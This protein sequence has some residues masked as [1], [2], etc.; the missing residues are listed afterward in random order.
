MRASVGAFELLITLSAGVISPHSLS[1]G[2][3][4]TSACAEMQQ[5]DFVSRTC[6]KNAE[7]ISQKTKAIDIH[8][9]SSFGILVALRFKRP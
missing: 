6:A 1:S 5:P 2:A 8:S 7:L 4:R 9:Q 3:A